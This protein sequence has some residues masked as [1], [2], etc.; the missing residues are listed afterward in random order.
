MQINAAGG[1]IVTGTQANGDS[2]V[3]HNDASPD[4]QTDDK[5]ECEL[6][7]RYLSHLVLPL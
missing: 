1:D 5:E 2:S 3:G 7:V 6:Q 4:M